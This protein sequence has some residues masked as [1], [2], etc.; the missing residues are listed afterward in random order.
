MI[1][2]P[3]AP[4]Q[5]RDGQWHV[6]R[7]GVG[8]CPAKRGKDIQPGDQLIMNYGYHEIVV[9]I[10]RVSEKTVTVTLRD[11]MGHLWNGC[12][13]AKECWKAVAA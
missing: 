8:W 12:R 5:S 3:Y 2:N 10:D 11:H 1:P 7:Q 9:S 6:W 4:F 13:I